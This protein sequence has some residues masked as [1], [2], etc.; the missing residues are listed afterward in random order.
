L[1]SPTPQNA[2]NSI[3]GWSDPGQQVMVAVRG[4]QYPATAGADGI[5]RVALPASAPT[6]APFTIAVTAGAASLTLTNVVYGDVF[7]CSGQ[8]NMGIVVSQAVNGSEEAA[9]ANYPDI[10]IFAVATLDA[11]DNVTVPQNNL[12]ASIPWSPV[13]G[14]FW[15]DAQSKSP[16][17]YILSS[18]QVTPNGAI[19]WFSALCYFTG[20][21]LY[22]AG[23]SPAIG[24]IQSCWGGT[25]IQVWMSPE[26]L[27]KCDG[28]DNAPPKG[29]PRRLAAVPS[30]NS[31]L[32]NAMIS[33]LLSLAI[34][35]VLWDQ[36]ESNVGQP[37]AYVCLLSSMIADW[38]QKWNQQ[39][40]APFN[41]EFPFVYRQV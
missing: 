37:V 6:A 24:L 10:R 20:R 28:A 34:K 5:F 16:K 27:H 12:T 30:V 18:T 32:F 35:G 22:L 8:S 40:A 3:W 23:E 4:Q 13:R 31:T 11:Y 33:P 21:D 41:P 19:Q 26:A 15:G 14:F 9:T 7:V 25:A 2:A 1:R 39:A 17:S 36:G 38:R 29:T